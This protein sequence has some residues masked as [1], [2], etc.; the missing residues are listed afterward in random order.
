ML[1][2]FLCAGYQNENLDIGTTKAF[3]DEDPQKCTSTG[4]SFCNNDYIVN[5]K[6]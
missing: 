1:I 3:E 5:G 4:L 6:T 2:Q